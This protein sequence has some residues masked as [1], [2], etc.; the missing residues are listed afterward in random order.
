MDCHARTV[1]VE[2]D[3]YNSDSEENRDVHN[4]SEGFYNC[5]YCDGKYPNTDE[6][7]T[8]LLTTHGLPCKNC[9]HRFAS[10]GLLDDHVLSILDCSLNSDD[11]ES[12]SEEEDFNCKYCDLKF[13]S[14]NGLKT[15][16]LT[17]HGLPC[18]NCGHRFE[19]MNMLD[20]HA[21]LK[22]DCTPNKVK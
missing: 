13:S 5:K 10:M 22:T 18:K 15:H 2:D 21:D 17:G 8:H 20:K 16:L 3:D 12:Q 14:R 11:K 1:D 6:L 19:N 7:K 9:G 4:Y